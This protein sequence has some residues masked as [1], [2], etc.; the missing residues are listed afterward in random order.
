MPRWRV[1]YRYDRLD[2]GNVG[3][4]VNPLPATD[5]TPS[6]HSVMADYS[7]SEFSRFR[8]QFARDRSMQGIADNQVMLQYVHSL[9]PHAAHRF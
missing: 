1:G 8:L 3:Y 5:F 6:R 2:A 9:G 7:L 4:G